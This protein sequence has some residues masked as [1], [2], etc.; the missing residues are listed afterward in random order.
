MSGGSYNYLYG[1]VDLEDL[2]AQRHNL[3]DMAQR[4]AGLGYAQDAARETEELIVLLRQWE[5]RAAVRLK[6]L[7]DVWHAVEWWDS[8]DSGEDA[9]REALAKY[10]R[11]HGDA[12]APRA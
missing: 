10:R 2:Q 8:C 4:L 7:A 3:E 9:V 11:D 1:A 5:I 12:G 6:R